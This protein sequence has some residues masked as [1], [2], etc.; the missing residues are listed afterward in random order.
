MAAANDNLRLLREGNRREDI[1][2]AR[3]NLEQRKAALLSAE[4]TV[5]QARINLDYT[6]VKAPFDGIVVRK[7][8]YPGATTSQGTPV[9]TLLN[10]ASLHVSANIEE[11]KLERVNVGDRVDIAIDAYRSMKVTGRV[12]QI[13]RATNSKFSLIPSEGVSGTF[14]KVAQRVPVLIRLENAPSLPLGPGLSV[15][16]RIHASHGMA[17]IAQAP[18][19]P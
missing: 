16:V 2:A 9:V 10:P 19:R 8:R 4:A 17:S 13:L 1:D 6:H 11:K 15:E 18:V 12:E 5:R 3:A 14:I 7:W